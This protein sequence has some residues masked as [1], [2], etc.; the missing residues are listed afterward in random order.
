MTAQARGWKPVQ[1]FWDAAPPPGGTGLGLGESWGR[2]L[3]LAEMGTVS[4][5]VVSDITA[6]VHDRAG[7]RQ[8]EM[9]AD[10]NRVLVHCVTAGRY[11]GAHHQIGPPP[12][13]KG[14]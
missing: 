14:A 1:A 11:A 2:L 13:R 8:L 7:L 6:V 4:V 5:I 10:D 12:L 9:W 3:K